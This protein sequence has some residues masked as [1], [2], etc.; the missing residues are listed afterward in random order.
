MS[1]EFLSACHC[2]IGLHAANADLVV[3]ESWIVGASYGLFAKTAIKKGDHICDYVGHLMKTAEA[4][5]I[6][7]K[8]YLMRLGDGVYVD[9]IEAP[10]CLA[11]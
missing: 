2:F 7:D 8:S 6:P 1:S 5:R 11:R 10:H 4:L 9:A 3:R